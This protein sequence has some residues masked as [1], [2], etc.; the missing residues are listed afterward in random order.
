MTTSDPQSPPPPV[1][2]SLL[3]SSQEPSPRRDI[4]RIVVVEQF[5]HHAAGYHGEAVM[6]RFSSPLTTTEQHWSRRTQ[7]TKEWQSIKG[8]WLEQGSFVIIRN[9]IKP[10]GTNTGQAILI[11]IVP[12]APDE[13]RDMHSPARDDSPIAFTWIPPGESMRL[14]LLDLH[15]YRFRTLSGD[16]IPMTLSL[17]P[18]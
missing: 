15:Q 7:A 5:Y 16:S 2:E 9:D 12:P 6:T 14:R 3:P 11:G 17:F 10:D 8:S 18:E 13:P 4:S 1:D